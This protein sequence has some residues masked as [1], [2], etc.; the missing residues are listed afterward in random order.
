MKEPIMTEDRI[1][2]MLETP[3]LRV[4]DL[5]YGEGRHYY[6][7]TRRPE[8]RLAATRTETEFRRMLPDAVTCVVVLRT[9]AEEPR[10]LLSREYRYPAG[11]FLL[12]PPAGLMDP[13][14]EAEAEPLFA[15]ARREIREETGIAA[16]PARISVISPLLFSSPGMTDESNA[17]V[18]AV[19]DLPD[20]SALNQKGADGS[21][22]FDGFRLLTRREAEKT[23]REGRDEHGVFYS[24]YTWAALMYFAYAY[25]DEP[26]PGAEGR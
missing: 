24:V 15:T 3:F 5:Q 13:E 6:C 2:P 26:S 4:V 9:P 11:R 22:C 7:A 19:Y 17:L 23:L 10:L 21:E 14:D 12:S 18:L 1:R 8:G 20:L 25:G 16:E